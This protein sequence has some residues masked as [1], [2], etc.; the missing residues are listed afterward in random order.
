M[1][2]TL[3]RARAGA[4]ARARARARSGTLI[5]PDFSAP[6][7]SEGVE[8]V[9]ALDLLARRQLDITPL[10]SARFDFADLLVGFDAALQPQTI[11]V[12]IDY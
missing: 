5:R 12:V 10:I 6:Y 1:S 7:T 4:R 9:V 2:R 11:K 8:K 3:T